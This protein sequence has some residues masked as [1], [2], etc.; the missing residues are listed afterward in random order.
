VWSAAGTR[1]CGSGC[2][3]TAAPLDHL[4]FVDNMPDLIDACD[5]AVQ[6]AGG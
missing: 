3:I 4:G 5:L 1:T 6:N 2:R